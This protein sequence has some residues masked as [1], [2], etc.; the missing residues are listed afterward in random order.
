MG[1]IVA[2]G[3]GRRWL[4]GGHPWLF[5]DDVASGKGEP[6]ELLPVEDPAGNPLGWGLFSS[7]SRIA[8]RMVSREGAQPDRAFW[9]ER[10][11]R[12]IDARGAAGMLDPEGACRLL[13]GDADGVPG[14]VV[15][16]YGTVAVLQSGCQGSD[17]MRDFLVELL[18]ELLPFELSAIVDRSDASVRRLESLESRVETLK[19]D[20]SG[21]IVVREGAIE[22]AVDVFE[23]HKTGAY[24]DQSENRMRAARRA[25][26]RRVLDSF[27][28]DGLFALHAA[29]AGAEEVVCLEQ[30]KVACERIAANAA[31]NGLADR[32]TVQRTNCMNEL[33]A[34]AE[35]GERYGLVIVDP[36][37]FA[38]NKREAVGAERGYVELNRRAFALAAPGA[39]LV[40]ASCSYNVRASEFV[41]FLRVAANLAQRDAWLTE[42]TGAAPDHPQLLSLPETSYLKCGFVRVG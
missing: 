18:E 32:I 6:G 30:N 24:L 31:R 13:A 37:A 21:P 33:R 2:S 35:A 36:P 42:L 34:R 16:R 41:R 29:H 25:S 4:N 3:K 23:G 15:D 5:A 28:Y 40:S 14:M 7:S 22:Y 26:G 19:G 12:A 10:M 11:R 8:V 17:R 1:K 20:A 9:L 27:S 39:F 38:R